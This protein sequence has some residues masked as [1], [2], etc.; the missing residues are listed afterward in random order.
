LALGVA[1]VTFFAIGRGPVSLP[2]A[3]AATVANPIAPVTAPAVTPLGQLFFEPNVGQTDAQVRYFTRA[4][5]YTLF[6][7]DQGAVFSI[8]QHQPKAES[9]L[10]SA[11][12]ATRDAAGTTDTIAHSGTIKIGFVGA[13]QRV[14]VDGVDPM[15]GRLNYMIGN[16]PSKWHTDV[17]TYGRVLYRSLYPGIDMVYYG[18]PGALEF[19]LRLAPGADPGVIRLSL[20]GT[21]KV[22]V[23]PSG[24]L[25]LATDAGEITLRKPAISEEL[26]GDR[27]KPLDGRFVMLPDSHNDVANASGTTVGFQVAAHDPSHAVVI[28]PQFLYSSY[29]GGSGDNSGSLANLQIYANIQKFITVS[30]VALD[31]AAGPNNTAYVSGLAYSTDFPTADPLQG[32][33]KGAA[34]K[35]PNAFIAKFDTSQSGTPSLVYSTFFGGSGNAFSGGSD[36]DQASSIAVDGN[37]EAYVAGTTYSTDLFTK[38]FLPGGNTKNGSN[39]PK[40]APVNNG[41]AL[42]LN[43]AGDTVVYSTYIHGS[44]GVVP[45]RIALVPG[46]ATACKAYITGGTRSNA[47]IG[48]GKKKTI[49]FPVTAN[50]FQAKN[51]DKTRNSAAFLLVLNG[52]PT[53][54]GSNVSVAYGTFLGGAGIVLGGDSATGLAVDSTAKAYLDGVTFS[55]NFPVKSAFQAKNNGVGLSN[56]FVSVIDPGQSGANSLLWSTYLGGA[57][58][59]KAK[60]GD[61]ATA[62]ALDKNGN[63]WTTGAT[64]SYNAKPPGFPT[65]TPLQAD[66]NANPA[67]FVSV[68]D[69][70]TG[71]SNFFVSEFSPSGSMLYSTYLGGG[72]LVLSLGQLIPV[73]ELGDAATGIKVDSSNQVWVTGAVTSRSNVLP[74]KPFP[75]ATSAIGC[76]NDGNSFFSGNGQG[77]LVTAVV[78]RLNA[79]SNTIPFLTFL[80]GELLDVPVAIAVDGSNHPYVAGLTYSSIFPVTIINNAGFQTSNAA[81]F[82]GTGSFFFGTTNAFMTELDPSSS[83]CSNLLNPPVQTLAP[84][85]TDSLT[86]WT[87]K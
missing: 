69:P 50:A 38:N 60:Q 58:N 41:F 20:Q 55:K 25:L 24:N 2:S 27:H 64:F 81:S 35:T 63:V 65:K 37:G 9:G 21:R 85:T 22:S 78:L 49:D 14:A 7:T 8:D 19:D 59:K 83:D 76:F 51:P 29:L 34:N 86:A 52:V 62:L 13:N 3:S 33:D 31:V 10:K 54:G 32:T 4:N 28:D 66:N 46:C 75:S 26:S 36:G 61:L 82:S 53:A 5:G 56:A 71:A 77:P 39:G 15:R 43:A 79:S 44:K 12:H 16:D 68:G 17:P 1:A 48:V 73:I 70:A 18:T 80:P 6:L 87:L 72:G 42:E 57:G 23:D 11:A 40:P 45:T 30:D 47:S 84:A 74:G 67:S